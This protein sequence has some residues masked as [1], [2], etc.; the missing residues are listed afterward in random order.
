MKE[1]NNQFTI[2]MPKVNPNF[3]ERLKYL[4]TGKVPRE[5]TV[6][7]KE[8][9]L[10]ELGLISDPVLNRTFFIPNGTNTRI[11]LVDNELTE[12]LEECAKYILKTNKKC[13][14]PVVCN[15][16]FEVDHFSKDLEGEIAAVVTQERDSLMYKLDQPNKALILIYPFG[17]GQRALIQVLRNL[18]IIKYRHKA[19]IDDLSLTEEFIFN[20]TNPTWW[21]IVTYDSPPVPRCYCEE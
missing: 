2:E 5:K 15:I 10:K 11:A 14:L 1:E 13:Q 21:K 19:S 17:D 4:F 9:T 8:E 16:K 20:A 3:W 7:V 18:Q 12:N 6:P